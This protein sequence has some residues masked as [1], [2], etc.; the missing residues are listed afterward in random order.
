MRD[1]MVS[2]PN[3]P[4]GGECNSKVVQENRKALGFERL[5][6]QSGAGM[7]A[8]ERVDLELERRVRVGL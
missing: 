1:A 8:T 6:A 2:L 3:Q 4:L 7:G 5:Q